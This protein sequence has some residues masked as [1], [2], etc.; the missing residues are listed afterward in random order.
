[1][2]RPRRTTAAGARRVGVEKT[3]RR[4]A[5][6]ARHAARR[7]VVV[8]LALAAL[9][10]RVGGQVTTVPLGACVDKTAVREAEATYGVG[11]DN[12]AF[13]YAPAYDGVQNSCVGSDYAGGGLCCNAGVPGVSSAICGANPPSAV[14]FIFQLTGIATTRNLVCLDSDGGC[15]TI[16]C[17][18]FPSTCGTIDGGVAVLQP[19]P[20]LWQWG[21]G[22]AVPGY[23]QL[24]QASSGLCM[25]YYVATP[26]AGAAL[27][28][29][30]CT[31]STLW[32]WTSDG[33]MQAY[34]ADTTAEP[35]YMRYVAYANV[36]LAVLEDA[37]PLAST[38][39]SAARPLGASPPPPAASPPPSP[40][41]PPRPP[42]PPPGPVSVS[43]VGSAG[44]SAP[45][46]NAGFANT[47]FT[48]WPSYDGV[49][50]LCAGPD[51][52]GGGLCCD[53]G[54]N[55]GISNCG[56]TPPSAVPFIFQ[57]GMQN[58]LMCLDTDSSGCTTLGCMSAVSQC[59]TVVDGVATLALRSPNPQ[60]W[61]WGEGAANDGGY[62][63]LVHAA[64]GYCLSYF[65]AT[66]AVGS[67]LGLV[68]CTPSTMW[69]WSSTGLMRLYN[70]DATA[71]ALY[72]Q[73]TQYGYPQLVAV[74]SATPLAS[75]CKSVARLLQPAP[76]P[77]SPSPSP[78]PSPPPPPLPSRPP[79]PSP[80]PLSTPGSFAPPS[81]PLPP[82]PRP[83]AAAPGGT[84]PPSL[85][86]L[87]AQLDAVRATLTPPS[88]ATGQLLQYTRAA[89]PGAAGRWLCTAPVSAAFPDQWCRADGAG[90][91][92]CDRAPPSALA[93][94]PG[95]MPPGGAKLLY[96]AA[97]GWACVCAAG[98]SGA[99]CTIGAAGGGGT[100]AS[101]SSCPAP[102]ACAAPAGSGAYRFDNATRTFSCVCARGYAG[103][104]CALAAG[105]TLPPPAALLP[106]PAPAPAPAPAF[107]PAPEPAPGP[108]SAAPI[109][110]TPYRQYSAAYVAYGC[111]A[112]SPSSGIP[113]S[114][115]TC[116][117]NGQASLN[118]CK[119]LCDMT[120]GCTAVQWGARMN[121]VPPCG[122]GNSWCT[123]YTTAASCTYNG[124]IFDYYFVN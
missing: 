120:S 52:A 98:W 23:L 101:S 11:F 33:Y 61:Q 94:P 100:P 73:N 108:T 10:A 43:T 121:M 109:P 48:Y 70:A 1:M 35:L 55:A 68:T 50:G 122:A 86:S 8:A 4:A 114:G 71:E 78:P 119:A 45:T 74:D 90:G 38:C 29:Q 26:V 69:A 27:N 96:S 107:G 44:C 7:G 18:S 80:P 123:L 99:S 84:T 91:V 49:P 65:V 56:N 83:P 19:T 60:L 5:A 31:A 64:S 34:N 51:Y 113:V 117:N 92:A 21:E 97:A 124:D 13:T 67:A 28:M 66:P 75:T 106:G 30:A 32:K 41:P 87:Q 15:G 17:M 36:Q 110:S 14:P 2:A 111:A 85:A 16:G 20:L 25:W 88:C 105:S 81:P 89:A 79:P 102:P 76:S 37:T 54:G 24:Q 118:Q 6:A 39:K 77:P 72:L 115:L 82:P 9:L 22:A 116:G 62:L 12:T 93:T 112:V 103:A 53:G 46:Y 95:C 42:A 3:Q 57:V 104:P 40:P 47:A 63:Q 58:A 59:G